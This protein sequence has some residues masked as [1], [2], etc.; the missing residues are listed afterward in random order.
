MFDL[1]VYIFFMINFQWLKCYF[2]Y[3]RDQV[4]QGDDK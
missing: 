4:A 2:L 3:K 1:F